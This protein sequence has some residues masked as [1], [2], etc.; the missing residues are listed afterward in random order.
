MFY[1]F[2]RANAYD[3]LADFCLRQIPESTYNNMRNGLTGGKSVNI[4]ICVF[5]EKNDNAF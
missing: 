2:S 4:Y 1:I 3:C 5:R